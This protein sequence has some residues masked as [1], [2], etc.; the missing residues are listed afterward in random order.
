M[1]V[2]IGDV[3]APEAGVAIG[4]HHSG[5][6]LKNSMDRISDSR[7]VSELMRVF[8]DQI[9]IGCRRSVFISGPDFEFELDA[10]GDAGSINADI[11]ILGVACGY[12]G[13]GSSL[14]EYNVLNAMGKGYRSPVSGRY[15]GIGTIAERVHGEG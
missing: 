12:W 3:V 10:L 2:A 4:S 11:S 13:G 6:G 7:G 14:S 15:L 1:G 5:L 9:I 8:L